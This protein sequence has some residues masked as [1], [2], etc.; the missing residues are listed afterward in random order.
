[1]TTTISDIANQMLMKI[2]DKKFEIFLE[3][4]VAE[5]DSKKQAE[6][7]LD[8]KDYIQQQW[9]SV[10]RLGD[11]LITACVNLALKKE[12]TKDC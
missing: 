8:N 2:N 3:K 12:P 7:I 1:M 5:D 4:L 9:K 6:F 11:D 10:S